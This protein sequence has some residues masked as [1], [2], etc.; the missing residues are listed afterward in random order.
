[1]AISEIYVDPALAGDVGA[2]EK[3]TQPLGISNLATAVFDFTG[4]GEGELHLTQSAAFAS[5]TFSAGDKIY[6]E[7]ASAGIV[8][9]A[10][11]DIDSKVDD[12]AILLSADA[13]LTAD[14]SSIVSDSGPFGDLEWAIEQTTFDLAEGTRVNIKN[15]TD[16]ILAAK[17]E[18]ALADTGTSIAWAPAPTS[19]AR[20]GSTYISEIAI[21]YTS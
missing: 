1:M 16:E 21:K 8:V 3:D 13:G 2:G 19:P 9:P 20:A 5:Y 11:Y 4:N 6:I 10:F 18:T 15:G 7:S 17:L 12:D 14:G